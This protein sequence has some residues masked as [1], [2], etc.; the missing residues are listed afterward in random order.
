MAGKL[1]QN[2]LSYFDQCRTAEMWNLKNSYLICLPADLN[3]L[4]KQMIAN[5]LNYFKKKLQ[6]FPIIFFKD[7][8]E[9]VDPPFSLRGSSSCSFFEGTHSDASA[10]FQISTLLAP[11]DS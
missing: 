6:T 9:N 8:N 5:H 2:M 10:H 7:M 3:L 11:N 4:K 1:L